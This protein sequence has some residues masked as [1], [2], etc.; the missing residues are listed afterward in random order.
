M[1]MISK[2]NI[3]ISTTDINGSPYTNRSAKSKSAELIQAAQSHEFNRRELTNSSS[4]FCLENAMKI[5]LINIEAIKIV[6]IGSVLNSVKNC[7][8]PLKYF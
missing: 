4:C 3:L 6:S 5:K 8:W 7:I 1:K 2:V